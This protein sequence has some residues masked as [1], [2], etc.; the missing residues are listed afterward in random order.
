MTD[1]KQKFRSVSGLC[2]LKQKGAEAMISIK[3]RRTIAKCLFSSS[4]FHSIQ[5]AFWEQNMVYIHLHVAVLK[6]P[7]HQRTACV[8]F[9]L[10]PQPT[11]RDCLDS[12]CCWR[13]VSRTDFNHIHKNGVLCASAKC[14][15]RFFWWKGHRGPGEGHKRKRLIFLTFSLR[16]KA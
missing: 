15:L 5:G 1:K 14:T 3:L 6:A 16:D 9:P 2:C 8:L 7:S 13:H 10:S 11:S 4:W 12:I